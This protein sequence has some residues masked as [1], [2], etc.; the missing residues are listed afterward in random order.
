QLVGLRRSLVSNSPETAALQRETQTIPIVFVLVGEPVEQGFVQSLARPGGN[1][2]GFIP[3]EPAMAG[4]WLELLTQ[5]APGG[6]VRLLQFSWRGPIH[7]HRGVR[8]N[9]VAS[10]RTY[11]SSWQQRRFCY[12]LCVVDRSYC[13]ESR[14]LVARLARLE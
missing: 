9:I 12:G 5:I 2:T 11:S 4:K 10:G 13:V 8:N 6:V 7:R 1:I 3:Q 14:H